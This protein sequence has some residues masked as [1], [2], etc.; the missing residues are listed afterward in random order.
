MLQKMFSNYS[1]MPDV[2]IET[3]GE[4]A[5][6]D[7]VQSARRYKDLLETSMYALNLAGHNPNCY[8][9]VESIE[10]GAIPVIVAKRGLHK[11]Y[12]NWAALYGHATGTQYH[13]IPRSP[14]EVLE[15]WDDLPH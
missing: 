4:W 5:M 13:W 14:M 1:N 12:D 6:H 3:S 9:I 11:C 15:S 7:T 2:L 8:R 10:S